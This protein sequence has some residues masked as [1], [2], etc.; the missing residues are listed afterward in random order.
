MDSVKTTMR[1]GF[2]F[3]F[4]FLL[5]FLLDKE[6]KQKQKRWVGGNNGCFGAV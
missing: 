6:E 2:F 1:P 3:L 5:F 4:L